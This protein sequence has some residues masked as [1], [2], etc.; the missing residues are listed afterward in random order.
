[1]D[2]ITI[3]Y[4]VSGA[5]ILI[6]VIFGIYAQSKIN[7]VYNKFSKISAKNG[8]TGEDLA[9]YILKN[10]ALDI[11]V[12]SIKGTLTDHYDPRNKSVNISSGNF[13]SSSISA[14]GVVAHEFGHAMQDQEGYKPFTIRQ[15]VIKVSNFVSKAFFPI[16]LVGFLFNFAYIGGIVGTVMI[17]IALAFY[18]ST[19]VANLATLP[20][21]IDASKR[22]MR[23]L[24]DMGIMNDEELKGARKVLKAAAMT[25]VASLLMAF[26]YFLRFLLYAILIS[27]DD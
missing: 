26:V 24:E 8:M 18:A 15:K 10:K 23:C 11:T 27:R 21:E 14:L 4:I 20:V 17:G 22:A 2:G 12:N 19:L 25:Y 16:V 1:M 6:A 9:K 13:N 3:A 5:L 7:S